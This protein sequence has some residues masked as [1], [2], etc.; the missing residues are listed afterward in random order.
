MFIICI[1]SNVFFLTYFKACFNIALFPKHFHVFPSD[2]ENILAFILSMW[3]V[4]LGS[5]IAFCSLSILYFDTLQGFSK[6]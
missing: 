5:V 3:M 2:A 6:L 4:I 1:I